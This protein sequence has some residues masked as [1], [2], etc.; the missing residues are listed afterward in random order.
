MSMSMVQ[1]HL[2][3][4][5]LGEQVSLDNHEIKTYNFFQIKVF[6]SMAVGLHLVQQTILNLVNSGSQ[7][8]KWILTE[9]K[10]TEGAWVVKETENSEDLKIAVQR[11]SFGGGNGDAE[12]QALLGRDAIHF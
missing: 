2:Q 12:E 5:Q 9:F 10:D 11:L 8:P 7:I 6:S 4:T 3:L 1:L